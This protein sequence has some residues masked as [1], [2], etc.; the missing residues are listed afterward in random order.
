MPFT[1]EEHRIALAVG[2]AALPA[3]NYFP[4]ASERTIE[5][6]EKFLDR[7]GLATG[8]KG[9]LRAI[10]T[11]ARLSNGA[12]FSK[13]PR[14]EREEILNQWAQ[15]HVAARLLFMGLTTPLKTAHF[16]DPE[17]YK[18]L[19]CVYEFHGKPEP[20]ERWRQQVQPGESI[21]DGEEIECDVLVA[22][23]GAGG[24]VFGKELAE[25]GYAVVFVEEGEWRDR[26]AFTGRSLEMHHKHHRDGGVTGTLG[27]TFIAVPMGRLVG[28]STAINT[29]TC[30]RTPD[31][32][33]DR[34]V[35]EFGLTGF[36]PGTMRPYF[37]QVERELQVGD[38]DPRYLG[39]IARVVARGCEKLGWSHKAIRR[40]APGCDGSGVC[41]FGCP[42]EARRS[43]NIS[44]IPPALK[45][46]AMV[47][48]RLKATKVRIENGKA[49]GLEAVTPDGKTK[50][51]R[52]RV[53]A[54]ACGTMLTPVLLANQGICNSSGWMGRNLSVHPSTNCAGLFDEEIKGYSSIPS[55]YTCD[56]WM[57]D[58]ILMNGAGAPID[59]GSTV[60]PFVGR[61]LIEVME[62]YDRIAGFGFLVSDKSNGRLVRLPGG[63]HLWHYNL[64][65]FE[66]DQLKTGMLR[67]IEV[68]RAAGAKEIYPMLPGHGVIRTEA[69]VERL[70]KANLKPSHW[71]LVGFHP[72]GTTR[73]GT[74]RDNSVLDPDQQSWDVPNL[75]VVD[76]GAVPSAIGVNSQVTIMTFATRAAIRLAEKLG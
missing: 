51:F 15:S 25:R 16:D 1:P 56:H 52:A 13:L 14:G 61:K 64:G 59:I 24:A 11:A 55:G 18:K 41:D 63:R 47:Y 50:K 8:Y 70:R 19:G 22:G 2:E 28:G 17:L 31:W 58:G 36:E 45:R 26:D 62:A 21:P 34:W 6:V 65:K 49:V 75:Y 60:F 33:L 27:N 12:P 46:G 69:D 72:L 35:S 20:P 66:M 43:T 23:T 39:G 10:E 53:T 5:R 30:F 57:K 67:C 48:T 38:S 29:G 54:L 40:N 73:I 7:G 74:R 68:F 37:E 32:V 76:G 44:Y 3:G 9:M 71:T 4:G 42:T